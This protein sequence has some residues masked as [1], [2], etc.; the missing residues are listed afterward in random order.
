MSHRIPPKAGEGG[1]NISGKNMTSPIGFIL[2][3]GWKKII[4]EVKTIRINSFAKVFGKN[5]QTPGH[6]SQVIWGRLNEKDLVILSG[7]FHTYEDY[8]SR[9]AAK[10]IEF[11][12]REGV[13]KVVVTAAVGGLNPSYKVGDLVILK[14]LITLFCQSPLKG[15]AFQDLSA[16]F[17]N[18]LIKKALD[19]AE[20][21]GLHSRQ[22]VHIYTRGPHY[23]SYADKKALRFLGADVVGMSLAPETILA[24]YLKMEVLGLALVTNLAFVKHSHKEVLRAAFDREKNLRDFLFNFVKLV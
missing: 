2:G 17:S 8:S 18:N 13:K 9:E 6:D 5:T 22:G 7:R 24:N 4:T 21:A 1:Q 15:P 23:E 12:H 19:A 10:T 3:S 11:L 20:K 14:D 16:P